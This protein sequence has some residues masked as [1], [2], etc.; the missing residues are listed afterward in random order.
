MTDSGGSDPGSVIAR[1]PSGIFVMTAAFEGRRSGLCATWVQQCGFE[2]L[3]ISVAIQRGH[4]IA[5]YIRDSHAFGLCQIAQ[6]NAYLIKK[7]NSNAELT[8][9][10]FDA[11]ETT[12]LETG[13]PLLKRAMSV[14]DCRVVR[15]IDFDGDH[16]LFIGEVVA[17][18]ILHGETTPFVRI[19]D[20]GWDY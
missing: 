1:V 15:H 3:L 6:E 7:F 17:S 16:E 10:V 9:A 5:P 20:N 19:R 18:Q 4:P 14:M 2:P 13:S 8:D 12:T 11:L